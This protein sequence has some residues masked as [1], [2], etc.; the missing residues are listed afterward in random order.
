M[1]IEA[2]ILDIDG[3]LLSDNKEITPT[4]K[5]SAYYRTTKWS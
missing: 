5:K 3:T 4:T 1:T 2:I